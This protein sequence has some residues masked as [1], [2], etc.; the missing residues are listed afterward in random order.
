MECKLHIKETEIWKSYFHETDI[1]HVPIP[2]NPQ[3]IRIFRYFQSEDRLLCQM[4]IKKIHD[5]R[6]MC[7]SVSLQL[8]GTISS[9]KHG[10]AAKQGESCLLKTAIELRKTASY[11]NDME[12]Q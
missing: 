4:D 10:V 8:P 6:L 11:W 12:G 2:R 9:V 3:L 7:Q 1:S 5:F